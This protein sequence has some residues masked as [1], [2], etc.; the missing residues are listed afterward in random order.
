M[1][2]YPGISLFVANQTEGKAANHNYYANNKRPLLS[3]C[4]TA[5]DGTKNYASPFLTKD[6]RVSISV[7]DKATSVKV[8]KG[9]T[10]I[11]FPNDLDKPL[12]SQQFKQGS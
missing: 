1:A 11:V 5:F 2:I 8:P 10:V 7:T 6:P 9:H 4:W 12:F 3:A